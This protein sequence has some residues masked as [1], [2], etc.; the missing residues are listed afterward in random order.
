MR[1]R[2]TSVLGYKRAYSTLI[3]CSTLTNVITNTQV[4][5]GVT[6]I[7]MKARLRDFSP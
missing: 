2:A 6:K 7:N 4:F 5:L 1:Y 3:I